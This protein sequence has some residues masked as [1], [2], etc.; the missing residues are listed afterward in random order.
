[1]PGLPPRWH[2]VVRAHH[3]E[4]LG[5]VVAESGT[6]L[7]LQADERDL[8]P[9]RVFRPAKPAELAGWTLPRSWFLGVLLCPGDTT[10]ALA[11]WAKS[12]AGADLERV[13]FYYTPR[14]R[15]ADTLAAW[16]AAALPDLPINQVR[17]FSSFHHLY[18]RH[19][20]DR[21]Y[22]DHGP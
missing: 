19:H 12:L 14:V 22:R 11:A 15:L 4:T 2:A 21:V 20:G 16:K 18:G 5:L 1:M 6:C 10:D 17:D 3:R 7:K 9:G 13:H 8:V